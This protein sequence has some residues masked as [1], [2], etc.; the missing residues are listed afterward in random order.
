MK[1]QAFANAFAVFIAIVYAICALWIITARDSLMTLFGSWAHGVDWQSLPY[2]PVTA[3]SLIA[4]FVTAVL[5]AWI[6]GYLFARLYNQ[7]SKK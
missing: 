2:A 4:G 1:V 3:T 7:F 5:A 6:A